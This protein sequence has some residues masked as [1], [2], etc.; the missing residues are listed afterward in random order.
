MNN[1]LHEV[2]L[3]KDGHTYLFRTDGES[4]AALL[5]VLRRLAMS[6][7]LTFSWHDAAV[8]CQKIRQRCAKRTFNTWA[9]APNRLRK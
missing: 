3:K 2:T 1:A 5:T 6:P 8:V 9:S 7:E 4:H